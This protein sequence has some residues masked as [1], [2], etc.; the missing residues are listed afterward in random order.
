VPAAV[1]F[2]EAMQIAKQIAANDVR[3]VR[4]TKQAIHRGMEIA[5][6]RTALEEALAIDIDIET[7]AG[8]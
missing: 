7:G 3:A 1:L 2:D 4:M 8:N 5:G 6:F